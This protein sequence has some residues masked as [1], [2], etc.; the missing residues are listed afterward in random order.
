M[1][2]ACWSRS[3]TDA[4]WISAPEIEV[5]IEQLREVINWLK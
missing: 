1:S 5:T 3:W 4:P 2:C